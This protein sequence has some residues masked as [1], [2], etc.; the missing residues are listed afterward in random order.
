VRTNASSTRTTWMLHPDN[1]GG[2]GFES[3]TTVAGSTTT[4]D[5]RHFLNAGGVSIGVLVSQGAVPTL[6]AGVYAPPTIGSITLVKVEFWHRDSLGS[7][8]ATTDHTAVVTARYSYDSFGKR[9]YTGGSYDSSGAIVVDWTTNT[10]NGTQR[11]F[12]GHEQL[13]DVGLVHMNGRLFDPNTGRFIQP[14]SMVQN[15]DNLQNYNRYGYCYNNPL[16]CTDPTGQFFGIDDLL[17]YAII[18]T[19]FADVTGLIDSRT[20]RML[21][22]IEVGAALP[23]SSGLLAGIVDNPIAQTAIAGFVSGA[24][25]GGGLKGGI[26]GAIF[27]TANYG[28]GSA[29]GHQVGWND[30]ANFAGSF[31]SHAVL[32]CVQS[33]SAG[34]KCGPGAL[35]GAFSKLASPL[36]KGLDK[37]QGVLVSAIIGGTASA[38]GGGKFVNGAETG[39][40]SYLFNDQGEKK[41]SQRPSC[42]TTTAACAV[43]VEGPPSTFVYLSIRDIPPGNPF[44]YFVPGD[45]YSIG[46]P[47]AWPQHTFVLVVDAISGDMTI[48][49]AGPVYGYLYSTVTPASSSKDFNWNWNDVKLILA[50]NQSYATV[51]TSLLDFTQAVNKQNLAYST[52]N[53]NS[54]SF[55]FS[56]PEYLGA[57]RPNADQWNWFVPG[58]KVKVGP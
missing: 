45:E 40:F 6:A 30:P 5:N 9:R 46:T 20:A 58:S 31:I 4:V 23:G 56:V 7:L 33:V 47:P 32:G 43:G 49:R 41:D 52:L 13:D 19:V 54:N 26:R 10:N 18:A 17:V 25:S 57:P 48:S 55:A 11:G 12:T 53:L 27:A 1:A 16:N 2:L 51:L 29:F 34:G 28:I 35:S 15:P 3:E 36:L 37:P 50:T 8:V 24:I 14:D 21:L 39:A 44:A 22:S 42:A 38:L